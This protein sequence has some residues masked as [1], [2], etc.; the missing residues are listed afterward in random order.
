M[1]GKP[2]GAAQLKCSQILFPTG[3]QIFHDRGDKLLAGV[4]PQRHTNIWIP[5]YGVVLNKKE[6]E[7]LGIF[8]L[9]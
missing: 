7:C 5:R 1:S 9:G 2:C 6:Q 8:L 4:I 3:L